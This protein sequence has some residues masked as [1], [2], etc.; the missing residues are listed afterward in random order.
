MEK[1]NILK[2]YNIINLGTSITTIEKTEDRDEFAKEMGKIQIPIPQSIATKTIQE[3]LHAANEIGFPVILRAAFALGGLGSGLCKNESELLEL[4]EKAFVNSPQVLVEK[5][6]HG[7][8][9]IEYEVMRDQFGNI[10]CICNMENFD[11]LGIHT[12]DSIVIVPSQTLNNQDYQRLREACKKIV[13]HFEIIGECNVQF[14]VDPISKDFFVIE[15]NARLSRSS[16]LASKASGYPIAYIAAKVCMGHSLIDLKNPLTKISS[17]YYEPALDYVVIKYPRWDFKK[18]PGV[19]NHLGTSMKSVGEIMSIGRNFQESF[20]KAIRMVSEK[21]FISHSFENFST[22]SLY[23]LIITPGPDRVPQLFELMRRNESLEKISQVTGIDL[24]FLKEMNEIIDCENIF[25][26]HHS[27]HQEREK[28]VSDICTTLT[29]AEWV[30]LKQNGF[31]DEEIAFL[32]CKNNQ[33]NVNKFKEFDWQKL[34][35]I[36]REKRTQLNIIPQIKKIDSSSGE[37]PTLSN[38]LYTTYLG[39]QNDVQS[40]NHSGIMILGGGSYRI[41]SSVEFDWSSVMCS[42]EIQKN[43]FKSILINCNPETVST[44]YSTSDRLYFEELNLERILDIHDFENSKGI[45]LCMGGQVPNNLSQS[46][47][48]AQRPILGSTHEQIN[49]AEDRN[50]FSELLHQHNLDQPKFIEA[51]NKEQI[52]NFLNKVGFP[53]LVRPS[54]VLSGSGMKVATSLLEL[55]EALIESQSISP[56]GSVLLTEYFRNALEVEVDGVAQTGNTIIQILSEHIEQAG[57]HSGDATHIIPAQ[58][59]L[60][61]QKEKIKEMI[62]N[63]VQKLNLT[64]PYN[65]QLLI[66]GSEIKV[67]EC[68]ARASRSFPFISKITG[69]NLAELAT[70]SILG[71]PLLKIDFDENKIRYF[72]AKSA[73]FSF[74]RLEGVDPVLGVEMMSTGES[75]CIAYD[76][77]LAIYLSL[78]STGMRIP[79]K[80]VLISSGS[81]T[82]KKEVLSYIHYLKNL[83][84]PLFATKGTADYLKQHQI[85]IESVSDEDALTLITDKTI[86]FVINIPKNFRHQEISR[87]KKIRQAALRAGAN[88]MTNSFLAKE[89]FKGLEVKNGHEQMPMTLN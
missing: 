82:E 73:M 24:W 4:A 53:V 40:L 41:G 28:I 80:G 43:N 47:S 74:K 20:K 71:I 66:N 70:R 5:S 32:I 46:L 61:S 35:L 57:V 36:V 15:I 16:A 56:F 19:K 64:G 85:E 39:T 49:L 69:I 9:E 18:F 50:L 58:R 14:A 88:L 45:I 89:Y 29:K 62:D 78:E 84:L 81:E 34:S 63:I 31:S 17:A 79:K 3:A 55:D 86:D 42:R 75:G 48:Y 77:N 38:Y 65:F 67:I 8:K 52:L 2:K 12:G 51:Q 13:A 60:K 68:N 6:L 23:G 37:F 33:A 10:I 1:A 76:P 7:F 54:H 26:K 27:I 59:I 83:N 22:E 44:D 11:P 21:S 87:G 72:G 25:V 30:K